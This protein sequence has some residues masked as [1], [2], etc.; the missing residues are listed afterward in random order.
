MTEERSTCST[1][2]KN[3]TVEQDKHFVVV[4]NAINQWWL[5]LQNS[6][7]N[8]LTLAPTKGIY[9]YVVCAGLFAVSIYTKRNSAMLCMSYKNNVI[10]ILDD[11]FVS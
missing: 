8:D 11:L 2:A 9:I 7:F 10:N 4:N 3:Q 1:Y 6:C 5:L